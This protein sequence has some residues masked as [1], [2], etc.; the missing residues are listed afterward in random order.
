MKNTEKTFMRRRQYFIK[1][2]FQAR[3]IIGFTAL[4]IIQSALIGVLFMRMSSQTLTTG[5]SGSRF[6]I[7]KTSSFFLLNF[8]IVS[9]SVAVAMLIAGC[10]VFV[11]L[12]HRIAGPL[13][14]FEH[15]LKELSEGNLKERI[16]LRKTDQLAELQ[17][18]VNQAAAKIENRVK[19]IK[20]NLGEADLLAAGGDLKKAREAIAKAREEAEFFKTS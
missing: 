9:V 20:K 2:S 17:D 18:A 1:K 11:Y 6:L 14:R 12:S 15:G 19:E 16:T 7:D 4:L 10:L 8:V 3:F 5:Y 13:Y